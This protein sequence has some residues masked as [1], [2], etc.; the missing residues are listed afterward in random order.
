MNTI[1]FAVGFAAGLA[2]SFCSIQTRNRILRSVEHTGR[3]SDGFDLA[4]DICS[5]GR[6][7]R[8]WFIPRKHFGG[9]VDHSAP[10][11]FDLDKATR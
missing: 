9:T 11:D 1:R 2:E 3:R 4:C 7:F 5:A 10:I 8:Q 6:R